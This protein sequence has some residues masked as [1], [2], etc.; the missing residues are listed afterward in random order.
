MDVLFVLDGSSSVKADFASMRETVLNISSLLNVGPYTHR[1]ALLEFSGPTRVWPQF[2]F[3][4]AQTTS[5]FV[6]TVRRMPYIQGTTLV[7]KALQ[8]ARTMLDDRRRDVQTVVLVITDGFSQDDVTEHAASIQQLEGVV[9]FALEIPE[10]Y[11][12]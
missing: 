6:E 3:G 5:E 2:P 1:V 12:M 8:T 4:F 7:G 11:N 9:M 10:A